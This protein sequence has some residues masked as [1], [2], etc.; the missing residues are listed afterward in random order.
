MEN[1]ILTGEGIEIGGNGCIH[2]DLLVEGWL[3]TRNIRGFL[4]GLYP[5]VESLMKSCPQPLAGWAAL[6][7]KSLPAEVYVSADGRWE[8]T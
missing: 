4:R 5:T 3:D 7:G 1:R 6:V 2:G 8:S